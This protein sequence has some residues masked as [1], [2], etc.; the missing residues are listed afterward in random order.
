MEKDRIKWNAKY[1]KKPEKE[2]PSQAVSRFFS[3]ADPG[4]A[5][6]IAC[7]TG[8]N[9]LFLARQGFIVD[10]VDISDVAL[11]KISGRHPQVN[12]ICADLDLFQ[13]PVNRYSLI[14]NI[15]FLNRRLFP[16]IREGLTKNGVLIFESYLEMP[17]PENKNSD[18]WQPSC[19]DY[20]LRENE[21]LHAFLSLKIRF[22]REIGIKSPKSPPYEATLAAVKG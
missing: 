3:M 4:R 14:I 19:R 20:L 6:D 5:L 12:P 21:L 22:Y 2:E 18:T 7:G 9:A 17:N 8:K 15:R 11:Q 13:I 16:Y 10:A 1:S